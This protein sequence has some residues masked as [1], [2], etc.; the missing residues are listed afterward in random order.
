VRKAICGGEVIWKP[1]DAKSQERKSGSDDIRVRRQKNWSMLHQRKSGKQEITSK[2]GNGET[3]TKCE[4]REKN[5]HRKRKS[6]KQKKTKRK[7]NKVT[8][9]KQKQKEKEKKKDR[10]F[11][12]HAKRYTYC[13][14]QTEAEPRNKRK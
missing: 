2:Q 7:K 4:R 8:T 6:G 10:K 5:G 13:K 9:S 11:E 14:K 1:E 12:R 3:N